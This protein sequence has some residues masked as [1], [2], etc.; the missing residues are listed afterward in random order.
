MGDSGERTQEKHVR[1]PKEQ[2]KPKSH[3]D[4]EQS[5]CRWCVG[6]K[7]ALSAP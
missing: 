4:G 6:S 2:Y 3:A 7:Q 1:N 5:Q